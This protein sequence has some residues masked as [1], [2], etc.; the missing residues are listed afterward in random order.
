MACAA[1]ATA[2]F[3]AAPSHAATTPLTRWDPQDSNVPYLAWKGD[4][5]RIV[6]CTPEIT[7]TVHNGQK[8]A[9]FGQ[10][11]DFVIETWSDNSFDRPS[12][13]GGTTKFFFGNDE[14]DGEAC[15]QTTVTSPAAGLARIQLD[16]TRAGKCDFKHEFLV[17]WL[18][19][20]TPTIR[21]VSAA[22]GPND[23]PGGGGPLGDPLGDGNFY[24][25]D[26]PGRVQAE[27]FGL[28]PLGPN[29]ADLR[30]L[31]GEPYPARSGSRARRTARRLGRPRALARSLDRPA[32]RGDAVGH[33]GHPRRPD[34]R[35][36][37]C[38]GEPLQHT[39]SA[40]RRSGRLPGRRHLRG[41]RPL[42]DGFRDAERRAD[43]RPVRSARPAETLLPDGLLGAGDVP[44]P[45]AR[46]EFAIR[47]T[48]ATRTSAASARSRCAT[49]AS[50]TARPS[51]RSGSAS[52][53]ASPTRAPTTVRA[54]RATTTRRSTV[55]GC[56]RRPRGR[57][58]SSPTRRATG[59]SGRRREHDVHAGQRSGLPLGGPVRLLAARRDPRLRPGGLTS[60][61]RAHD[62]DPTTPD[63][64]CGRAARSA[65][66][67]SRTSTARR[68]ST[69]AR[70]STSST[71]TW[72]HRATRSTAATSSMSPSSATQTSPPPPVSR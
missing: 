10:T 70:A 11:A 57:A 30:D 60:C 20:D 49:R 50:R 42:L 69:S 71:T 41:R 62:G 66:R 29:W 2:A 9:G 40:A 1:I 16:L 59:R 56:L 51:S 8:V 47:A 15:V 33:V 35:R 67:S 34:A 32:L 55:A 4:K 13:V 25:G 65:S 63:L 26:L 53:S 46:V 17:G 3:A 39:G 43:H 12:V 48:P 68:R 6:L 31:A 19:L 54:T 44:M 64:A 58:A 5:L 22:T 21:E 24:A 38:R 14:H 37:A 72:D 36:G 28:L 52:P 7:T 18:D 61:L 23:P 27:V 45:A